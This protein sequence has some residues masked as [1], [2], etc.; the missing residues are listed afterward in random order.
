[1]SGHHH[2]HQQMVPRGAIIGAGIL[3]ATTII[4]VGF[5]QYQK[6][7]SPPDPGM[8]AEVSAVDERMVRFPVNA[9]GEAIAVVDAETGERIAVL[10]PSDGFVKTV[11]MSM[12]FNRRR[13]GYEGDPVFRLVRW[14]DARISIQD[15]ET[16]VV[17]N[18]GAFGP[19]N[20]AVFERFL[21]DSL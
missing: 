3:I 4:I 15:V 9:Q 7:V 16:G 11:L 21:P 18:L 12:S 2:H 14:E 17:I 13:D 5:N 10:E 20:K 6:S 8:F 19:A 1:M